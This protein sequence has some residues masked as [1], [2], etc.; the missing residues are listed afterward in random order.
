MKK[1]LIVAGSVLA[2]FIVLIIVV[3]LTMPSERELDNVTF[4]VVKRDYY[5]G[6][7]KRGYTFENNILTL[8]MGGVDGTGEIKVKSISNNN[9]VFSVNVETNTSS[10]QSKIH[11][12]PSI[13]VKIEEKPNSFII[14]DKIGTFNMIDP[15][16]ED[17]TDEKCDAGK[18]YDTN[19]QS[20]VFCP[21]NTYSGYGDNKCSA[22]PDIT[23]S[24]VGSKSIKSCGGC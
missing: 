17:T 11:Q 16:V 19:T 2:F 8:Y 6:V 15:N 3:K 1:Y 7:N 12:T 10:S 4:K 20:C 22:C 14:K 5:S 13:Q 23:C 21:A 9:G 24:P 18:Y